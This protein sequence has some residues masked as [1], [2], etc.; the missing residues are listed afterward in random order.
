MGTRWATTPEPIDAICVSASKP[1]AGGE[2]ER[3]EHHIDQRYWLLFKSIEH[4]NTTIGTMAGALFKEL[5]F[6]LAVVDVFVEKAQARLTSRARINV[7]IG[8]ATCVIASALMLATASVLL[9]SV[10][11]S[12]EPQ[13]WQAVI[14]RVIATSGAVAL[15]AGVSYLVIMIA[16][17]SFHEA[18]ILFNRRHSL[19]LGRLLLYLKLTSAA[20]VD[21][22]RELKR[23]LDPSQME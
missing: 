6:D 4:W 3:I 16:R 20:D 5:I 1:D 23:E 19:R 14:Y 7:N 11:S 12:D 18:T 21:Q 8:I 22:L 2:A 10:L 13:S 15:V 9:V 17:A